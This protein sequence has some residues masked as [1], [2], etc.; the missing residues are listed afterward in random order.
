MAKIV[1]ISLYEVNYLGTRLLASYLRSK[2]H[3]A[4]NILFKDMRWQARDIPLENHIGY[5]LLH[6][7]NI[8]GVE[9]DTKIWSGK[10]LELL[11]E[12]LIELSPDIIGLSTRSPLE[13]FAEKLAPSLKDA[14]P[15]ALLVAGGYGPTF[16]PAGFLGFGF[17]AVV[18]GDGEETLLDLSYAI[19]SGEEWRN[20]PNICSI[21]NGIASCNPLRPQTK[22][23]SSFPAPAH[24]DEHFSFIDNDSLRRNCDP[25]GMAYVEQ[26]VQGSYSTF[27]SRGC[28]GKCTYCSGGYWASIYRESSTKTYKCRKR[29]LDDILAELEN[30]DHSRFGYVNFIDE[31]F[32]LTK[33]EACYFFEEYRRRIRLPFSIYLNYEKTLADKKLYQLILDSGF[34][35]TSVGIQTGSEQFAR[36][37][38]RRSGNNSIYKDYISLLYNTFVTSKLQFIQGNCYEHEYDFMRTLDFIKDLPF[39]PLDPLRNAFN[40]TRLKIFPGAPICNLA[41]DVVARPMPAREWWRRSLLMEL[42]RFVSDEI[43]DHAMRDRSFRDDPAKLKIFVD[44]SFRSAIMAAAMEKLNILSGKDIIF[45]GCGEVLGSNLQFLT[46]NG[47]SPQAI[48][49]DDAYVD[50]L[51]KHIDGVEIRP[52]SNTI[53]GCKDAEIIAFSRQAT[54]MCRSLIRD[55]KYDAAKLHPWATS[56]MDHAERIRFSASRDR[57][58]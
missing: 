50:N 39:D 32:P 27:I 35:S 45:Y 23:I 8:V 42:R 41:P 10:E 25:L 48:M 31:C 12:R 14:C 9:Y 46:R 4:H 13:S 1:F 47:I 21:R 58:R 38:Y 6:D 52:V 19:D 33:D 11:K 53:S 5:Q 54:R 2:G 34:D 43:M 56:I 30:I 49:V 36:K 16:N 3:D 28:T 44:K 17:D 51:P 24:G 7:R 22:D 29:N 20:L 57:M 55:Y 15:T 37:Y 26:S 40:V 18:R